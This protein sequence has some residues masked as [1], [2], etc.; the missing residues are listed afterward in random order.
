LLLRQS[1]F[2]VHLHLLINPPFLRRYRLPPPF[3]PL[4]R[5]KQELEF[6]TALN[7]KY[8]KEL[9]ARLK[10]PENVSR[11]NLLVRWK[12]CDGDNV[13]WSSKCHN[14]QSMAT[15]QSTQPSLSDS[16]SEP[17][18]D[19]NRSSHAQ[20]YA[21]VDWA[22]RVAQKIGKRTLLAAFDGTVPPNGVTLSK[23]AE[24]VGDG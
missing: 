2:S 6:G 4:P 10:A 24:C 7:Q 11:K 13:A 23:N 12:G 14:L 21:S 8:N 1:I 19:C 15:K 22:N 16:A 18:S 17:D 3:P 5:H 9:A 20:A